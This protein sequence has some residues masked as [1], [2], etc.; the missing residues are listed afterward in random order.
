[1]D[2]G[3]R[4]EVCGVNYGL[5]AHHGFAGDGGRPPGGHD[6]ELSPDDAALM[7]DDVVNYTSV[8]LSDFFGRLEGR[9][10]L[11]FLLDHAEQVAA[12]F[13]VIGGV[14][15]LIGIRLAERV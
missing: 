3:Q 11:D 13:D 7:S 12:A 9:S 8:K 5:A 2:P 14:S 1:M 10:A 4:L 15:R 6:A